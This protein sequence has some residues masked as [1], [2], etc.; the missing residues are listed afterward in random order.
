MDVSGRTAQET[1]SSI[2]RGAIAEDAVAFTSGL[3]Q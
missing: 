2:Y 1:K 3:G